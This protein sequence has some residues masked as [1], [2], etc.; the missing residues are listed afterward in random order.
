MTEGDA[1]KVNV[2]LRAL[3]RVTG[4]KLRESR[5]LNAAASATAT[6]AKATGKV[7]HSLWLQ[8]TGLVFAFFA[9]VGGG[10]AWREYQ[11]ARMDRFWLAA[12]FTALFI[13]FSI[14][15]FWKARKQ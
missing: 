12:A 10:A 6:T 8:V 2:Y 14:T 4:R 13:W 5:V 15:S 3:G 9:L 11:A 1:P 7:V